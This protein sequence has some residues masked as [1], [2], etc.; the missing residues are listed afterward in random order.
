VTRERGFPCELKYEF[1]WP[2]FH[3]HRPSIS[4]HSLAVWLWSAL[5]NRDWT[6]SGKSGGQWTASTG[7]DVGLGLGKATA[8]AVWGGKEIQLQAATDCGIS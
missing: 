3:G 7:S 8:D 4:A 6:E 2:A 1:G 5:R